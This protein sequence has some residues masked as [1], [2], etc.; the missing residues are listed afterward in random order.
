MRARLSRCDACRAL[1]TQACD[2]CAAQASPLTSEEARKQAKA[3]GLKLRVAATT[4][5]GYFGVSL[6]PRSGP[7][8]P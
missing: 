6:D 7:K 4:Q 5:T 3:E 2:A 1:R 8:Q